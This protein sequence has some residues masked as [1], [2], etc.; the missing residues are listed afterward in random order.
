MMLF[1]IIAALMVLAALAMVMPVLWRDPSR[2]PGAERG[3]GEWDS[4]NVAIARER[5]AELEREHEQGRLD[6]EAFAAAK[7]E[8]ERM[9]LD[10]LEPRPV[11]SPRPLSQGYGRRTAMAL[12]FLVP[13]VTG[14][15]YL[16]LGAPQLIGTASADD[17]V[18]PESPGSGEPASMEEMAAR[19]A[20]RLQ[21]EPEDA[22]GWYT[23]GRTYMN[24]ERYEEAVAALEK[25]HA[26]VGEKPKVM[27]ALADALSMS[28]GGRMSGRAAEL[29]Q[30]VLVLEPENVTALWFA[31]LAA[32]EA[33]DDE[34]A[35]D[36]WRKAEPLLQDQ[37]RPLS[38]LRQLISRAE[39][40]LGI[41]A[42]SA[43]RRADGVASKPSVSLQVQVT[44][45]DTLTNRVGPDDTLFIYAKAEAGPP[46]PLAVVRKRAADL[47][48]EVNL[49]DGMAMT[50]QAKLSA[51]NKVTIGA[52]I[53]RSG[54]ALA[55]SGDLLG[56]INGIAVGRAEPVTVVIN[57]SVP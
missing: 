4:H 18:A 45:D 8:L 28:Q 9:L 22:Q 54:N 37:P 3:D 2:L 14:V 49:N 11:E 15:L 50:P 33:G 23:L 26:L 35:I 29:A 20:K 30:R 42:G 32:E 31:G 38:T 53:S 7:Q 43:G 34:R 36:Y 27:L 39:G 16:Q 51:F 57:K 12:L 17:A 6:H 5:F 40:R 13:L 55:Q 52:R 24:M 41:A 44:L 47:P 56:E 21:D 46:I 48:L 19:L 25:V 10:D 1:W